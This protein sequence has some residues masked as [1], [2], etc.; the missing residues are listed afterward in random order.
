MNSQFDLNNFNSFIDLAS[1]AIVCDSECQQNKTASDLENKYLTAKSNLTL[2]E[3]QYQVAKQN[4]YT[5][6]SGQAGY[7]EMMENEYQQA[8]DLISQEFKK[9]YD[10]EMNK[11]QI[12]LNTFNGT[13]MNF[14]NIYELYKQY[15]TENEKLAKQLKNNKN[16]T[17]TNERKSYYE[18]QEIGSLN[19]FYYY[20][21]IIY[22][23]VVICF[24]LFSFTYPSQ[25]NFITRLLFLGLFIALP[26]IS[27]WILGKII[28]VIYWL[29]GL[30]PKNVYK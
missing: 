4:Y 8:A 21:L 25:F 7:D 24:A 29:F 14:S 6:V 2:A 13:L 18:D 15:V 9:T 10:E 1:Q 5:F 27:T 26:F 11:I 28:F 17:L 23:I 19:A 12:Q 16:D 30:L 3:P 20:L 22:I